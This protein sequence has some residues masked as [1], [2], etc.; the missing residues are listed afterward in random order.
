MLGSKV[1]SRRGL[2]KMLTQISMC[3]IDKNIETIK[4]Y[5][6]A[7]L[8]YKQQAEQELRNERM[9]LP[10]HRYEGESKSLVLNS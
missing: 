8:S 6:P 7:F 4:L 9:S 10:F 2:F 5:S 3:F 1:C